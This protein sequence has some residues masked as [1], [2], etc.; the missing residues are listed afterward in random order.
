MKSP[1]IKATKVYKL[2]K[3]SVN[4]LLCQNIDIPKKEYPIRSGKTLISALKTYGKDL[5]KLLIIVL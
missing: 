1:C 4:L 3:K 2:V 5:T